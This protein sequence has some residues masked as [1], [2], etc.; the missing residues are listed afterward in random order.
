M[1]FN[2]VPLRRTAGRTF[3]NE[4]RPASSGTSGARPAKAGGM[5]MGAAAAT[6]TW[7][8][9]QASGLATPGL[10][11]GTGTVFDALPGQVNVFASLDALAQ[12]RLAHLRVPVG[13][14]AALGRGRRR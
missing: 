5:G 14:N 9:K 3:A 12:A 1:G 13:L 2:D 6:G 10:R 4:C 7:T 8:A 11:G